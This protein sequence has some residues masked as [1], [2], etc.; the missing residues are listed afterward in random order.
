MNSPTLVSPLAER[1]QSRPPAAPRR[2]AG[3]DIALID[4]MLNP[5]AG[6][7]QALLDGAAQALAATGARFGRERRA[8]LAGAPVDDWADALASRYAAAV[9]AVGD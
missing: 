3:T 6:W 7:G 2:L 1:F 8:P 9:I 5:A 4:S